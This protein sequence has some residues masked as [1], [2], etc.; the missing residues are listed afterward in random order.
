MSSVPVTVAIRHLKKYI[1]K[2]TAPHELDNVLSTK[3]YAEVTK[4]NR[5]TNELESLKIIQSAI[6]RYLKE[7]T[8]HS[9]ASCS[10]GN[11]AITPAA[12]SSSLSKDN[13]KSQRQPQ[14]K[15]RSSIIDLGEENRILMHE[16]PMKETVFV[17][18]TELLVCLLC[19]NEFSS[20]DI[21]LHTK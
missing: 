12:P 15:G 21:V 8:I 10:R 16:R 14:K 7:K 9:R 4:R 13:E 3:F 20:H 2:Q 5:D 11:F 6:Q 19:F 1:L 18:T 17:L